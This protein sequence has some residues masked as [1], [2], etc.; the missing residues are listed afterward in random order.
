MKTMNKTLKKV[1]IIVLS[2]LVGC[3]AVWGIL[4]LVKNARRGD[5]NVYAATDFAMT[6]YW[7]DS[8][9]T[10]GSVSTD[11]L[12]KVYVS[13]T[14]TVT[15]VYVTEGQTVHKG[16]KLLSYDTTLSALDLQR[17]QIALERAKQSQTNSKNELDALKKVKDKFQYREYLEGE[18]DKLDKE[19]K[20][21]IEK[22]RDDG[23]WN[24]FDNFAPALPHYYGEIKETTETPGTDKNP[25]YFLYDGVIPQA[26][27]TALMTTYHPCTVAS[28]TDIPIYALLVTWEKDLKEFQSFQ[29]IT[30]QWHRIP[31]S[32]TDI[33]TL[34]TSLVSN[35]LPLVKIEKPE[36]EPSKERSEKQSELDVIKTLLE[37]SYTYKD[38][39]EMIVAAEKAVKADETAL[40]LAQLNLNKIKAEVQ[41]GAVYSDLDGVVKVVRDA[42]E[43]YNEGSAV[44]EVSGGGGYYVT[45]SIGEMDLQ[46]VTLGQTVTINSWMTG[47]NCEG[48]IIEISE[49]PT[50][51]NTG[52]SNG[53]NNISWYPMKIFVSDDANLQEGDW[54]DISYQANAENQ[55]NT[56]YLETMFI[57]T[58]NGKS[59]VMVRGE[60]GRLEQRFIQTGRDLWG[61]YTEVRGG[62]T[63]DDY[64]AFPYGKDVAVGAKTVE[65]TPDQFY[66]YY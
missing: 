32:P 31:A 39:Q 5:V 63:V 16:D 53:N 62:L 29:S 37:G 52:W 21:L 20:E 25:Y 8:T 28:G 15:E 38:L 12:Q 1:L 3:A 46:S 44:V 45:G 7:G 33:T 34:E 40:K 55:G 14:Q 64:V 56:W 36:V 50:T 22:E 9:S 17:A 59:Y 6:D 58:E 60:D 47:A 57:R 42:T 30:M 11:R 10:S 27:M 13:S 19:I 23:N 24:E 4:T 35:D 43:A 51:F 18:R 48:E 61:S 41:D 54:V 66:N 26:E 49:Y 2:V 65:S